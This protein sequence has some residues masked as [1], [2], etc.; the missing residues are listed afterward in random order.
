[1]AC[2]DGGLPKGTDLN[3]GA[4]RLAIIEDRLN[5]M[6]RKLHDWDSAHDH[7]ALCRNHH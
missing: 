5:T 7:T 4:V 3:V 6:P 1:M 2:W